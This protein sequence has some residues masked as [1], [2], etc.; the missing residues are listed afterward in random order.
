MSDSSN[1]T[2]TASNAYENK[3]WQYHPTLPLQPGPLFTRPF[4][5]LAVF[6]WLVQQWLPF[7]DRLLI[8]ILALV[9]WAFFTPSLAQSQQLQWGWISSLLLRNMLLMVLVAGGLHLYLNI[10]KPQGDQRRFDGSILGHNKRFTF[11]HQVHDNIFWTCASGVPIWTAYEVLML[12]AMAHGHVPALSN[13]VAG[14]CLTAL[15]LFLIPL[16]ETFYFHWIH[17]L[18]HWPPLY[19]LAHNVHH[20]NTNVGPWS[21]LSMHPIEHFLY[22]GTVLIHFV[23]PANPLVIIYHLQFFALS[24]PTSHA[25]HEGIILGNKNVMPLG[26]FFHQLHHRHF[27]CNYGNLAIPFDRWLNSMHGGTEE[28]HQAFITQRLKKKERYFT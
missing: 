20:R 4:S 13:T 24:A 12:W 8:L 9:S 1:N 3:H 15:L 25:G 26:G 18:L 11:G 17:R 21:G 16:W 7:S 28:S 5:P 23:V 22:L 27:D 14:L 10:L 19:R 6:R 2:H